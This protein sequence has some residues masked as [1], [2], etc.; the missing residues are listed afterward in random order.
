MGIFGAPDEKIKKF[1][2]WDIKLVQAAAIFVGL[3]IAKLLEPILNIYD[4]N[5]WWFIL[6]AIACG[7]KPIY[8]LL[9]SQ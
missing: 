2:L 1:T 5:I 6:I 9:R 8:V 3:V 4:I 7:I